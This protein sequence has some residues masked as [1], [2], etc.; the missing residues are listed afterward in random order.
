MS[1]LAAHIIQVSAESVAGVAVGLILSIFD[2]AWDFAVRLTAVAISWSSFNDNVCA[3]S[4]I[5][6]IAI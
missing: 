6:T 1:K 4:R 2:M 5:G 3:L